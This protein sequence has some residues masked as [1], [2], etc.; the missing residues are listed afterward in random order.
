[1]SRPWARHLPPGVDADFVAEPSTLSAQLMAVLASHGSRPAI[2]YYGET[3]SYAE[4]GRRVAAAAAALKAHGLVPGDRVALYLPN[5]PF[6]PVWFLAVIV[7]GGVVTHFSPLDAPRELAHK[8]ADSG[9]RIVVTLS[10]PLFAARALTLKADGA[11]DTII[12]CEDAVSL[13]DDE[14]LFGG[15]VPQHLFVGPHRNAPL[16]P[17]PV[18]PDDLALL[19]YTG[20]TTGV[21]KAAMLTHGNLT[22]AMEIYREWFRGTPQNGPENTVLVYSPLFHILGLIPNLLRRLFDGACVVL[23]QRFQAAEAVDTIERLKITS[24]VGVPTMW[25]AVTQLPGIEARDL[26]SLTY[27]GSGGAPLS[28]ELYRRV[29]ALTGLS[30]KGGWGMTETSPAGT[31]IPDDL[32]EEKLASIGIPLPGLDMDVVDLADPRRVLAPGE[33]GELRIRGPNVTAGYW[34]RP[35]ESAAAFVDGWLLTGDVGLMDE[36]GYFYLVDRKKDL[37]VSSGF[38]VYPLVIENAIAE[39]PDVAEVIVIG[40]PDD[41]RGQAAKAFVVLRAGAAQFTLAELADFL[42]ERI[43]R[44]EMPREIE[45]RA[46]LPRTSVGKHSRR[47]LKEELRSLGGAAVPEATDRT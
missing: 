45:F 30:L 47:A 22:A 19:Q 36:D 37:I 21:P 41:Y 5:T 16:E 10:T 18:G 23:R 46:E 25:I 34:R 31:S 29:R 3:I 7:A 8:A 11:V 20:G 17:A 38:N 9:A 4:L 1:M 2:E 26:S 42:T 13:K 6:H 39:H 28:V 27:V 35:E 14:P 12:L 43:G 15:G 40:V 33:T 24:L 32:P 44:H